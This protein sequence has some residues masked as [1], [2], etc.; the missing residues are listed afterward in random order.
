MAYR[1]SAHIATLDDSNRGSVA[2]RGLTPMS[3]RVQ[4]LWGQTP[5]LLFDMR[6]A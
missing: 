2:E 6:A 1:R 3:H 5:D 4:L